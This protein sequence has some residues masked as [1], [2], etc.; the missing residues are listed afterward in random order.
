VEIF[1][2][3]G[4]TRAM[5]YLR[6]D[7]V[8]DELIQTLVWAATRAP[9]PG[10]SQLWHF[11]LVRDRSVLAALGDAVQRVHA[12]RT[13]NLP[14]PSDPSEAGTR[15]GAKH[16]IDNL[17]RVPLLVVV[18]AEVGYPPGSPDERYVASTA[19]PAAQNLVLAARALGLGA[20]FTTFHH[21][22]PDKFRE[23]LGLPDHVRVGAVVPVGWP[24]RSFGPVRRRLTTDVVHFERWG[25]KQRGATTTSEGSLTT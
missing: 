8:P 15:Q 17:A 6:E 11:V 16:L 18:A 3:M 24:G 9:S 14:P 25:G 20:T 21:F 5:R 23:V 2:V 4:T 7:P 12:A 22:A 19:L 1:D 10:N 13:A